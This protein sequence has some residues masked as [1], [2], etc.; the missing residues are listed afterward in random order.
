MPSLLRRRAFR[1]NGAVRTQQGRRPSVVSTQELNGTLDLTRERRRGDLSMLGRARSVSAFVQPH[2][3]Q[4]AVTGRVV[5][6]LR[7]D[8]LNNLVVAAGDQ[9]HVVALV[10]TLEFR[11]GNTLSLVKKLISLVE[12]IS[13]DQ[14]PIFPIGTAARDGFPQRKALDPASRVQK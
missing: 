7:A 3:R 6:K 12:I 1:A 14:H 2:V 11:I 10:Q 13:R 8:V 9:R 4:Q 5:V